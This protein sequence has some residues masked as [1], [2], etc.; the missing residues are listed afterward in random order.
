MS[1]T[2]AKTLSFTAFSAMLIGLS[3][4]PAQ[5]WSDHRLLT[6]EIL[7]DVS[8]LSNP[9]FRQIEVTPYPYEKDDSGPYAPGFQPIYVD[10]LVGEKTTA[11]E[12]LLRYVDE[13]DW[14][15]DEGLELSFLQGLAGGSKGFRHQRYYY[16]GGVLRVGDAHG[17]AEH[18]YRMS[19][20]AFGK[21]DAYWGF[22]FLARSLHYVE[23]MGQP[24]HTRPF[25]LRQIPEAG[26]SPEK[27]KT[28]ATNYHHYYEAWVSDRLS[29]Q[30]RSGSGN[31]VEA[32][33]DADPGEIRSVKEASKALSAYSHKHADQ[34]LEVN[35]RYWPRKVKQMAEIIPIDA[36]LLD[37]PKPPDGWEKLNTLTANALHVTA[38]VSKG[39]LA[40]AYRDAITQTRPRNPDSGWGGLTDLD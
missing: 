15:M 3:A 6:R 39:F 14:G 37:P 25:R 19:K 29:K 38:K 31:W 5:A 7:G 18:F 11:R 20:L 33:R 36:R 24:L 17:R 28:L 22:R 30:Q 21:G 9:E 16:L 1:P 8:W 2:I 13:P 10:R 35:E 34:L 23:D 12:I 40:F 4:M 26:F 27:L 32:I